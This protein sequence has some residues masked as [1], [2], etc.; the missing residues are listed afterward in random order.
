MVNMNKWRDP[1]IYALF[2]EPEKYHYIGSTSVN[3]QNRLWEH[4][5]RARAGHDGPVYV[6]MREVGIENVQVSVLVREPDA[7]KR[8]LV[9]AQMIRD[10][11]E[12]GHLLKNQI[13]RDGVIGSMSSE[14]KRLISKKQL[15][16]KPWTFGKKGVE[17]GWTEE[18]RKAQSERMKARYAQ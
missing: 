5:C 18:R 12:Q 4:I 6:W 15:G 1:S 10:F 3:A 9:E 14:S 11:I 2:V 8:K 17:A 16:K 13:S 7:E